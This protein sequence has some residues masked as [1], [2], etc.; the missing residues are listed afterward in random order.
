MKLDNIRKIL[1]GQI[2][3][4]EVLDKVNISIG[5][6]YY[7]RI[8]TVIV[9]DKVASITLDGTIYLN[10][11]HYEPFSLENIV[12]LAH[13][14]VH[15]SQQHKEK[16]SIFGIRYFF[17]WLK[18]LITLGNSRSAYLNIKYEKEARE[19]E[20]DVYYWLRFFPFYVRN[21]KDMKRWVE[22]NPYEGKIVSV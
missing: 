18:Y 2:F 4:K 19:V 15:V 17:E 11:K 8:G 5:N 9:E 14:L 10:L 3:T 16:F 7:T 1:L 20:T 13:E 12:L 21:E 22:S 6:S